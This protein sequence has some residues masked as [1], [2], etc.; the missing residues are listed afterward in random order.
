MDEALRGLLLGT[1]AIENV[2]GRRVDWGVRSQGATLPSITL[3]HVSGI[4]QMHMSGPSGWNR[5]RIQIDSWGRT[6]KAASDLADVLGKSRGGLL[7]GF[8]GDLPGVRIRTFV[9]GRRSDDDVD[10]TDVVH[11]TS[12]DVM[13]WHTPL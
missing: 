10:G 13:V 11:R 5:A 4:P 8:R 2:V 12:L 1:T 7:V 9:I 6:Y 3:H